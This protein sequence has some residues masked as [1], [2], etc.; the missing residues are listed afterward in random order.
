MLLNVFSNAIKFTEKGYVKIVTSK[1][2]AKDKNN[3]AI[4]IEDTGIGIDQSHF[5]SIFEPFYQIESS[6]TSRY[7]GIG[8][9][10]SHVKQIV[11]KLHGRINVYSTLGTG[12]TFEIILPA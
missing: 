1:Y 5:D 7:H 8:L 9:G 3:I 11:E 10:L 2:I 4:K 6:F 12:S